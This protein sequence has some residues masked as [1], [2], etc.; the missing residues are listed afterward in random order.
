MAE[1]IRIQI[2][3]FQY[4]QGESIADCTTYSSKH[5]GWT[6]NNKWSST[7][8]LTSSP[9]TQYLNN[10]TPNI[11]TGV[12]YRIHAVIS[13]YTGTGNCGFSTSGG[14]PISARRSSDGNIDADF[15]ATGDQLD[16]FGKSTNSFTIN[17]IWCYAITEVDIDKSIIGELDIASHEDFPLAL[18][19]NIS[20]YKNIDVRKGSF[21]KTFVIPAT[22]NNNSLLKNLYIPNSTFNNNPIT[23]KKKC[24]IIVGDLYSLEGTLK[25]TAVTTDKYPSSYS[26][27][28]F[29]DNTSW[30]T[31][32]DEQ[33]IK[34]LVIDNSSNLVIDKDNIMDTWSQVDATSTTSPIVYPLVS[35]GDF[36][37]TDTFNEGVQLM[38]DDAPAV[39][40][41]GNSGGAYVGDTIV[42]QNTAASPLTSIA[43]PVVD[44]RPCIWVY[45]LFKK[46]FSNIGYSLS[47]SFVESD[48]FKRLLYALPNFKYNNIDERWSKYTFMVNCLG[49]LY[50]HFY[51]NQLIE[52][53]SG[54]SGGSWSNTT[55]L[56]LN[57]ATPTIPAYTVK[58]DESNGFDASTGYWTVPEYGFYS[59]GVNNISASISEVKGVDSSGN[60]SDPTEIN[61]KIYL[62][63]KTVGQNHWG[64]MYDSNGNASFVEETQNVYDWNSGLSPIGTSFNFDSLKVDGTYLNRGDTIR[65]RVQVKQRFTGS[66]TP[67]GNKPR[68]L[69]SVFEYRQS[70][71]EKAKYEIQFQPELTQYGQT[72][73]LR[74]V[75]PPEHTQ[76]DFIKGVSHAF[77]L[78]FQTDEKSKVITMEPFNEFY[79]DLGFAVD[80]THKIDRSRDIKD[81]WVKSELKRDLVFKYKD[82]SNDK[83]GRENVSSWWN[84]IRDIYPY[85]ESLSNAFEKGTSEYTNPFFSGTWSMIDHDIDL[86]S[87]TAPPV[88]MLST[89][90]VDNSPISPVQQNPYRA[91][92]GFSFAPRLL[93][94]NRYDQNAYRK[95]LIRDWGMSIGFMSS[96]A[97]SFGGYNASGVQNNY[98][99][100]A[101]SFDTENP[102][103]PN[104]CYG[105]VWV[106]PF[107][108]STGVSAG[109]EI[110]KGLFETYYRG[111]IEILKSNPRKRTCYVDLKITDVIN[112]DF[113]N[114]IYIDGTYWRLNK[115]ID[116]APHLNNPT[117][118]ELIEWR[119]LG[120][121]QLGV[122]ST[123]T[124]EWEPYDP[125]L[126]F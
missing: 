126:G 115:V 6:V 57:F 60:S 39:S 20:D 65:L 3:D 22:K 44:W 108:T 51:S 80:W 42:G 28:F 70:T 43:P 73:N 117:K 35:Y 118:V 88:A 83:A 15:I 87:K 102:N 17:D 104:L 94:Y 67:S 121:F 4:K 124:I 72:Y 48:L 98:I 45:D 56:T 38:R 107:D 29:G 5:A 86:P 46:I 55:H 49:S 59:L 106:E 95:M 100:Q 97:W 122:P 34:D 114:L 120:E 33:K 30:T 119:E 62:V 36:N 50:G 103:I 37:A 12:K 105:N 10:I 58:K 2:S 40:G 13:N 41:T 19:F 61:V 116:Y 31:L 101:V 14:V 25:I 11:Q 93:Y 82:D 109:Q 96:T 53:S 99:P 24:K 1:Q 111:M 76:I 90:R 54:G 113:R 77:N 110:Q 21:S 112:L 125:I 52:T 89:E 75:I 8:A 84:D 47:S 16:L 18:T 74:D 81:E 63:R 66:A 23:E 27:V 78:Q 123:Y 79:K 68:F 69:L 91:D 26:C 71:F 92:K 9:S 64:V 7:L 85:F 32:L